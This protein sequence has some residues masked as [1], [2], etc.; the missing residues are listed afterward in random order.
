VV[1]IVRNI[2]TINFECEVQRQHN[3][4]NTDTQINLHENDTDKFMRFRFKKNNNKKRSEISDVGRE[5]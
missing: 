3:G 4:M 5:H 2:T 1:E